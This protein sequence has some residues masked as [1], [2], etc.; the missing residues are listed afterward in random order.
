MA[1]KDPED[2]KKYRKAWHAKN[3]KGARA[4]E[5]RANVKLRRAEARRFVSEFKADVG[6]A[7]CAEKD[8][9]CLDFHHAHGEKEKEVSKGVEYGWSKEK[10]LA[11]IQKCEVLCANCHRKHHA[12]VAKR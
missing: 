2:Q 12:G 5:H 9:A 3:Y 10:I 4:K 6:C 8:P 1:Y 7:R 11:E